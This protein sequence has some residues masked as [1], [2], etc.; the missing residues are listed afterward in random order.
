[1]AGTMSDLRVLHVTAKGVRR[2]AEM[3]AADLAGALS[4]M[5]IDQRVA[6]LQA[7]GPVEVPFPVHIE[8]AGTKGGVVPGLRVNPA[9]V[10]RLRRIIREWRPQVIQVHGGEPLKYAWLARG[11]VE[12]SIVYRRI[13][14]AN[15]G[16]RTGPRR[17]AHARLMRRASRIIAVAEALRTELLEVFDIAS[18]K[19]EVIPNAVD[20]TR[21]ANS[22]DRAGARARLGLDGR[23]PVI[24]SL[25]ALT[26]EKDPLTHL[27][28]VESVLQRHPDALHLVAGD[29]P[30]RRAV[31]DRIGALRP[32][33]RVLMLG[34]RNDVPDLLAASDVLLLASRTE[35]MPGVVIEAGMMCVPTAAFALYGVPEVVEDGVTGL[36]VPSGDVPGLAARVEEL[37]RDR[38]RAR[39]MG[40]AA[41][42]RC[43]ERFDIGV[44]APRY[45]DVYEQLADV[46]PLRSRGELA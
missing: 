1:M 27:A 34:R 12:S 32:A 29:G 9:T 41:R 11:R 30:L 8:V 23:A 43:L 21:L 37:L 38:R 25:G 22:T 4:G 13:G 39:A 7:D 14:S 26:W 45:L 42:R 28:V 44:V 36:V 35:G 20:H 10:G 2:G 17:A 46:R 40:E 5:G 3:F 19:V 15:Y 16:N 6:I 33:G 31:E 18:E 24:L